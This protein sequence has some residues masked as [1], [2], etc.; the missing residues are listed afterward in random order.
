MLKRPFFPKANKA[1]MLHG[2]SAGPAG[3]IQSSRANNDRLL[4]LAL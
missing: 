3:G 2:Q 4:Q 1:E